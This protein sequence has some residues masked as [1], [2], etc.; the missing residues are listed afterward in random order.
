MLPSPNF[1]NLP[2]LR[3]PE[4]RQAEEHPHDRGHDGAGNVDQSLE[5]VT[6]YREHRPDHGGIIQLLLC[7]VPHGRN[8]DPQICRQAERPYGDKILQQLIVGAVIQLRVQRSHLF[9]MIKIC[10]K[11]KGI[12]P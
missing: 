5:L 4:N 9:V 12:R 3:G 1:A 8:K 10:Q 6:D 11:G 7:H 2:L